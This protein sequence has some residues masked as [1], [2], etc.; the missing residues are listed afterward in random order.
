V[1][2]LGEPA[3]QHLAFAPSRWYL[4]PVGVFVYFRYPFRLLDLSTANVSAKQALR[5]GDWAH[6]A[7]AAPEIATKGFLILFHWFILLMAAYG[8]WKG[9]VRKEAKIVIATVILYAMGTILIRSIGHN[10]GFAAYEPLARY[11]FPTEPLI[12]VMAA[13]GI[14]RLTRKAAAPSTGA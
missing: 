3:V 8:F 9:R 2:A 4:Y 6:I 13:A 12:L 5:S 1:Q 10:L 11:R 7:S 14:E